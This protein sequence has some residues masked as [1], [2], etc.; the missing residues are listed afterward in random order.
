MSA[1]VADAADE[2]RDRRRSAVVWGVLLTAAVVVYE[3][4][5]QPGLAGLTLALKAGLR[6][7]RTAVWLRY[8]D[9]EAGR[10]AAHFWLYVCSGMGL[11]CLAA[12]G[13]LVTLFVLVGALRLRPGA[14]VLEVAKGCGLTLLATF[15]VSLTAGVWAAARAGVGG[16][17]LWL[18]GGVHQSRRLGTWP[19]RPVGSNQFPALLALAACGVIF[20]LLPSAY[21]VGAAAAPNVFVR[22]RPGANPPALIVFVVVWWATVV[23]LVRYWNRLRDRLSARRPAD[24]W[25][26][27][28][29]PP[30]PADPYW[31]RWAHG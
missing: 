24:A 28:P 2:P 23:L 20:V 27:P 30:D 13:L 22:P 6:D 25:P 26:D 21:A 11:T 29:A 5:T 4:T 8:R 10:G 31:H 3:L 1:V 14:V 17:R 19:P 9:P 15:A 18:S 16:H 12:L 7:F